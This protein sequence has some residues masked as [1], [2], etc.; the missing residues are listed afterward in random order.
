MITFFTAYLGGTHGTAKSA[1]DF[2]RA[3]LASHPSVKVV[4]PNQE[5]YPASMC[6]RELSAPEWFDMPKGNRFPITLR[7]INLS[8]ISEWIK[9]KKAFSRLRKLH[10]N[11]VVI[12]N[13][14]ASYGHWQLVKDCF[15]GPKVIIVRE[16]PRHFCGSDRNQHLPDLLGGFS[17]FDYLIFVS[18][19]VCHEWRQYMEIAPKPYSVLPNCC[20]EEEVIRL[21]ALDRKVVREQLGFQPDDFVVLCPGIIEHRKGQDLLL[22]VLPELHAQISNLRILLVGDPLAQWGSDLLRAIPNDMLGHTVIHWHSRPGIMDLLYASDVLAFPSRAEAMPRTILEAMAMKTPVVA[23]DVDGIPELVKDGETGLLFTSDHKERLL[24][25]IL[26][27]YAKPELRKQLSEAGSYRYWSHFSRQNQF[28]RMSNVIENIL[29]G[30]S[31]YT[32]GNNKK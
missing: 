26:H 17:S 23:S 9:D 24:L 31:G 20:E 18:E 13:G 14:W 3:L 15:T 6:N 12:V 25:A 8:R 21:A 1:R 30:I 29:S 28:N 22:N 16:S 32:F 7:D 10:A 5:K 27:L 4:S 19:R 2:L 11:D